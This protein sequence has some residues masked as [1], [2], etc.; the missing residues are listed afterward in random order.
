MK[1]LIPAF[2]LL[3]FQAGVAHADCCG[4]AAPV[5]PAKALHD[6][7]EA[8]QRLV[9]PGPPATY[10]TEFAAAIKASREKIIAYT[11]THADGDL[12][13]LNWGNALESVYMTSAFCEWKSARE[14]EIT[15]REIWKIL[16][17]LTPQ[18]PQKAT[19]LCL[20]VARWHIQGWST[21][22]PES[23]AT[24]MDEATLRFLPNAS[25]DA[26]A[27]WKFLAPFYEEQFIAGA[28][29]LPPGRRAAFQQKRES[30]L[31]LSIQDE[32]LPLS[33]SSD[34]LASYA[35]QLYCQGE[36]D[37]ATALL[38]A[39]WT[40]HGDKIQSVQFYSA[41]FHTA[42]YGT[43]DWNKARDA[44]RRMDKLV[45]AKIIPAEDGLYKLMVGNYYKN[46]AY[47]GYDL[48]RRAALL[49]KEKTEVRDTL[50]K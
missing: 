19:D 41:R 13:A 17:P 24:L 47:S 46:I 9:N 27:G 32:S 5:H 50:G 29:K 26:I 43:G 31:L 25:Q 44:L 3:T 23:C 40:K 12:D 22:D 18:D 20:A 6:E 7:C 11:K 38:D 15:L 16:G 30:D 45:E 35:A 42:C 21:I 36:A 14:S 39:W 4:N 33:T 8:L 1:I 48:R 28:A 49:K 2:L 10:K 34:Q 37:R